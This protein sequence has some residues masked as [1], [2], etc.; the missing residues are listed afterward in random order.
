MKIKEKIK[1]VL[2]IINR[3]K[4]PIEFALMTVFII[5]MY[6][7]ITI[8]AY[9]GY[10]SR[11]ILI[12]LIING[13]LAIS[14]LIYNCIQDKDK[15]EKMFLNFAIPVGLLFI[16][17]MLPTYT[18]DAGSHIWKSYEVSQGILFTKIDDE[19]NSKTD[20]PEVLSTYRETVLTKYSKLNEV[21]SLDECYNYNQTVKVDSASKSYCFIYFIG[22]AIGFAI[23]RTIGLNIFLGLF[24]AKIINF[25]IFLSIGY[26]AIRKIPFG[27][28][29]LSTYL[30]IPMMMQQATAVSVDSLMN[31]TIILFIAYTLN[32]AFK[33]ENLTKKEKII[34]LLMTIFVGI[35]KLT[36]LPLLGLGIILAK[37]RKEMPIKEK[38]LFGIL[39][40]IICLSSTMVL[41]V[42]NRGYVNESANTYL[43]DTGVN[44]SEQIK[45]I[46]TKPIN[47][48]KMLG[49]DFKV[50]G[51]FYLFNFIGQQMGWLSITVPVIYLI[52]YIIL[53]LASIFV[54]NNEEVLDVKERVWMLLLA[55]LM[56]VLIITGLYIEWT[57][58]GSMTAAGIQG[59]Y[60]LP[61][62][63]IALLCMCMKNNYIKLKNV[64]VLVPL[65]SLII[66]LLFI[67]QIILFFI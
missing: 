12:S 23:A 64:N 46:I 9:E 4:Y 22:Y 2:K 48:L 15:I 38:I 33:K 19:G 34:F 25:I 51:Q 43:E 42:L 54:E 5:C 30:M 65:F 53:L 18:P 55:I 6:N 14:S 41:N 61:V 20:V 13:I 1:E 29:L 63:I 50:N 39:A 60:F 8:K 36:Y 66:N 56:Y 62:V 16:V 3:I 49:N 17:F 35:S 27:K 10:W 7:F 57:A 32:L 11:K 58:V 28:I 45:G 59:R 24:L 52:Y 31:A 47:Y 67:K 21:L 37:R 26:W 40:V 44:S